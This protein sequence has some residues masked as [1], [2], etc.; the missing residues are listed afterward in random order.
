MP[1]NRTHNWGGKQLLLLLSNDLKSV[2]LKNTLSTFFLHSLQ[3]FYFLTSLNLFKI[4]LSLTFQI[5]TQLDVYIVLHSNRCC[6]W[7]NRKHFVWKNVEKTFA[8]LFAFSHLG[9]NMGSIPTQE[10]TPDVSY[11]PGINF[12]KMI[13]TIPIS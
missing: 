12:T 13:A 3:N 4:F 8:S 1:R 6:L 11:R 10:R 7:Y 2:R 9:N 5:L